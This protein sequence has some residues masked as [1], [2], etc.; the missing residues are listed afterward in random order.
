MAFQGKMELLDPDK[1]EA[2]IA[3]TMTIGE[4]KLVT[5]EL[6]GASLYNSAGALRQL[7]SNIVRKAEK[8]YESVVQYPEGKD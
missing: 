4:W 7:I 3:V 1:L 2:K 5:E 6:K 8:N